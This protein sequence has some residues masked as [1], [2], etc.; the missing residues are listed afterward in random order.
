MTIY[1]GS[2]YE[3][4]VV[5]FVAVNHADNINPVVFYYFDPSGP[6]TYSTYLW[7]DGDR[8]DNLAFKVYG[9]ADMWW[10]IMDYNPKIVDPYTIAPG[11]V[12]K[13]PRV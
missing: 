11:T 13:V 7:T 4:S 5:D 12:I 2:R 10:L 8:L 3:G 6:L 9:Q 1:L